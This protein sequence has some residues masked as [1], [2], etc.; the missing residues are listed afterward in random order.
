MSAELTS[1][2]GA[3]VPSAG[4]PSS[5]T[6]SL[7]G[8]RFLVESEVGRG[9]VGIV[10]RARDQMSG[11]LVALK[12]IAITGVDA[13]EEARFAREGRV[14]AGLSHPGIVRVVAFGQLERNE[15]QRPYIALSLR[16]IVLAMPAA[17]SA[18]PSL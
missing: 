7:L 10:Y 13:S 14:L 9:G 5:G 4:V 11:Q 15:E 2:G 18:T 8:G 12:S 6:S 16:Q 1:L 3:P 17:P